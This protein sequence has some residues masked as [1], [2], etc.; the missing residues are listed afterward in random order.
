MGHGGL[1]SSL[2][3]YL[4]PRRQWEGNYGYCGEVSLISAGLYYGQYASQYDVRAIAS[5]GMD[6]RLEASQ[7]LLGLNDEYA[8]AQMQLRHSAWDPRSRNRPAE[9]LA[10]TKQMISRGHPVAIGVYMNQ[11]LFYEDEDPEAGDWDYDHIV[12]VTGIRTELPA[13]GDSAAT[14]DT[15]VFSDNGLWPPGGTSPPYLFAYPFA[16]LAASRR[17]AN[18]GS[19]VY[20][21]NSSYHYGIAITGVADLA[22]DTLPVRL[23]AV[24]SEEPAIGDGSAARPPAVPVHLTVTIAGLQPGVCYRLYRYDC[25][26]AVPSGRFNALAAQAARTW[27]VRI[28]AGTTY[29]MKEW[30][31]SN[32]VAVYRAVRASAS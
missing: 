22:G 11:R 24:P 31:Q 26:S 20:S 7:L 32:A 3:L 25:F 19:A 8:A 1:T 4:P 12:P 21:L 15:L 17:E 2:Q 27:D 18:A 13:S 10:W 5:R 30:I 28:D 6:Q 23:Q 9:F 16:A 14:Q 29:V